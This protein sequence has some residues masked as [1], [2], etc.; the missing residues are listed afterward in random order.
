MRVLDQDPTVSI[1]R[2][3]GACRTDCH[4]AATPVCP[5]RQAS[6]P[7]QVRPTLSVPGDDGCLASEDGF[8]HQTAPLSAAARPR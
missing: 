6:H 7:H 5:A 4:S 8:A 2:V 1:D 3:Y